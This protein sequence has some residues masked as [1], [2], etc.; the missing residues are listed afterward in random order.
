MGLIETILKLLLF[1]INPPQGGGGAGLTEV[2]HAN[3]TDA[4]KDKTLV[5]IF[6]ARG[7]SQ[8]LTDVE[9]SAGFSA[10]AGDASTND[11]YLIVAAFKNSGLPT[12]STQMITKFNTTGGNCNIGLDVGIASIPVAGGIFL[13]Q[14]GPVTNECGGF[15]FS[16]IGGSIGSGAAITAMGLDP[17]TS[18]HDIS[19]RGRSGKAD[20]TLSWSIVIF[21]IG[22]TA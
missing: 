17:M 12:N 15:G 9:L 18:A 8:S 20:V 10:S 21:R 4:L 13:Y 3:F 22:G 16:D 2:T 7:T 6:Q 14:H 11:V 1:F 19:L 5:A